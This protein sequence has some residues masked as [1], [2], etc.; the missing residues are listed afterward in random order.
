MKRI[1]LL[2][3]VVFLLFPSCPA[4]G[5]KSIE[6][7]DIFSLDFGPMEDQI[8]MY[9]LGGP[10]Q[11]ASFAMR[12]GLFYIVDGAGGKIAHYNS[13]G[14]LLFMIYNEETNPAPISLKPKAEGG[15]RVTRW[16]F[17][18][19]LRQ[20]GEITVDSNKHI[21]V[22]D[23]LPPERHGFDPENRALLDR[24]ILHF[25]SDGRFI[26]YMGQ[27]GVGGS[28]FPWISG[29]WTSI[30]DELAV[31]CRIPNGWNIY[32]FNSGNRLYLVRLKSSDIPPPPDWPQLS[33]SVDA[34]MA[35]PDAR[36]LYIKVDYYRDTL[37][38]STNTRT[39]AEPFGSVI[40][41]LNVEDGQYSA[42]V[43]LPFFESTVTENR[44]SEQIRLLYSMLGILK[45]GKVLL[46]SPNEEGYSV[47]FFNTNSQ[48]RQRAFIKIDSSALQFNVFN[49][50]AEGLLS[51]MLVNDFKV[52]MAWWRT[53]KF[54]G[55][56]P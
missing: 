12:D 21:F 39:G 23:R 46:Y 6:R 22:E 2:L 24:V 49:L 34:V 56:T 9:N 14:D 27:E 47:M 3:P 1:V 17:T 40:W 8:A 35:A 25:D 41:I 19:P 7:D 15:A 53:D 5:V 11:K 45:N 52:T 36:K 4:P 28:P 31:V 50:S 29:M 43:K 18:Y 55:E 51:A 13:Y 44:Q 20:P 33:S 37:D 38:E 16:A 26:E 30:H 48:E 54:I 10:V 32:W 42:S